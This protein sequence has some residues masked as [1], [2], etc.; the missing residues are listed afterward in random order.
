MKLFQAFRKHYLPM[1]LLYVIVSTTVVLVANLYREPASTTFWKNIAWAEILIFVLWLP[2]LW[3]SRP[4]PTKVGSR[5]AAILPAVTLVVVA[6]V[7]LAGATLIWNIFIEDLGNTGTTIQLILGATALVIGIALQMAMTH[8]EAG[9]ER[10]AAGGQGTIASPDVLSAH[11]M[12]AEGRLAADPALAP[13]R[14]ALADLRGD[15]T[16]R[17]PH[18]G[19]I[20]ANADYASL[21]AKVWRTIQAEPPRGAEAVTQRV[22]EVEALRSEIGLIAA[23]LRR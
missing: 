15:L 20:T 18:V 5:Q 14:S 8:A 7:A 23:Q 6:Y 12:A 10:F 4:T 1:F 16:S 22:G 2:F 21:C 17:L 11:L 9:A 13:L 3:L 19:E